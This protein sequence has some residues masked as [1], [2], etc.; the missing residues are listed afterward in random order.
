MDIHV[1]YITSL[2]DQFGEDSHTNT[3]IVDAYVDES[4]AK[5]KVDDLNK[6]FRS[7]MSMDYIDTAH[8]KTI[9]LK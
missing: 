3:E 5:G 1:V 9:R 4:L 6:M 8:Y 2:I 7:E